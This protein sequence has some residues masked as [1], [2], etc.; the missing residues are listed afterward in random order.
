MLGSEAQLAQV[1]QA[2]QHQAT[3]GPLGLP[4]LIYDYTSQDNQIVALNHYRGQCH[5]LTSATAGNLSG[6][7][8][9]VSQDF[10]NHKNTDS[11]YQAPFVSFGRVGCSYWLTTQLE[12][13]GIQE[14]QLLWAN[15]DQDIWLAAGL[16]LPNWLSERPSRAVV[17]LGAIASKQLEAHGIRHHIVPH[18]AQHQRFS[19]A[20]D[21]QLI[22]LL[23]ELLHV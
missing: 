14:R 15:S 18:P 2:Y 20:I 16:D 4:S 19:G 22:P 3:S 9:L 7:V 5:P 6:Q 10:A 23:R 13:G 21:Y 1:Y 8:C 17:A 11:L 12:L